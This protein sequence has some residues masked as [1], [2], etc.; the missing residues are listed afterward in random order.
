MT[1]GATG[2][3]GDVAPGPILLSPG[4][5][6]FLDM[7]IDFSPRIA[8]EVAEVTVSFKPVM[9]VRSTTISVVLPGVISDVPRPEFRHC[10]TSTAPAPAS[11][12][13]RCAL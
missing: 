1:I 5:G 8:G 9:E 12:C 3:S 7:A 2:Y 4:I 13:Y 11:S 6:S 10:A